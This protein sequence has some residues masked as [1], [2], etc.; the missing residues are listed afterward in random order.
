ML[1]IKSYIKK[2]YNSAVY[3]NRITNE[4][5][6]QNLMLYFHADSV[7]HRTDVNK[8]DMGYGFI[9]YAFIRAMK[10]KQVL[11]VGSR[12]GYIPA[13]LAQACKENDLG[14]V[15][16]VDAGY[17][18]TNKNAWTGVGF[19]K[20]GVGKDIFNKFG[21]KN[22]IK[23]YVMTTQNYKSKHHNKKY[24]YIY[25]DGNHSYKGVTKDY[26]LFWPQLNKG[27]FMVFHDISVE[28]R[29]NEGQYGVR[30]LW[31]KISKHNAISFEFAKSG[32]GILQKI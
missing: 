18:G 30:R 3:Q 6:A 4:L 19:W 32:L 11:C 2:L 15:H 24:D 16:F 5:S 28:G 29:K 10:P 26:D 25:I 31:K 17:G 14:M 7:G 12:H 23:L 8:A 1:G 13:I 21:L 27:G 20:T 22:F 9:H